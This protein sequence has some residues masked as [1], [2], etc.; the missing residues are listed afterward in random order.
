MQKAHKSS[1]VDLFMVYDKK[2]VNRK[3]HD[4]FENHDYQ[5]FFDSPVWDEYEDFVYYISRGQMERVVKISEDLGI[6][7]DEVVRPNGDTILHTC[8]EYGRLELFKHFVKK[9][10]SYLA[11]NY[12]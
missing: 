11:K 5:V 10:C 6:N 3:L 12:A 4:M 9:G 2:G 7:K 1:S 8:A